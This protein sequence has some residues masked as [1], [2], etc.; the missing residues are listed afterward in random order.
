MSRPYVDA[1]EVINLVGIL[2]FNDNEFFFWLCLKMY[3]E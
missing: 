2:Y 3:D 1:V